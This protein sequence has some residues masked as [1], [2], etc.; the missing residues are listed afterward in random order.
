[1]AYLDAALENRD[2]SAMAAVLDDVALKQ[3]GGFGATRKR[4]LS[5]RKHS[6]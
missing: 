3:G 1:M 2:P 6:L 5:R 4:V